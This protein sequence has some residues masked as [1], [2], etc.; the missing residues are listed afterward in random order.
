MAEPADTRPDPPPTPAGSLLSAVGLFYLG[1]GV[2]FGIVVLAG[3]VQSSLFPTGWLFPAIL[4]ATG[5]LMALRRRFDIVATLW[6]GLAMAVFL[7]DV[8]V[9]VSALDL[10]FDDPAAFDATI[11]V[12]LFGLVALVFRPQF[13][14]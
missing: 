10:R 2:I 8:L 13:R 9:H 6:A 3:G 11:I 5:G 4:I 7:L 14:T 12:A 1:L